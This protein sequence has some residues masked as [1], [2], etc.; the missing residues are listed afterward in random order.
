MIAEVTICVLAVGLVVC[1]V[2]ARRARRRADLIAFE[3]FINEGR[4]RILDHVQAV[5]SDDTEIG[6]GVDR[7]DE[8][9]R[10]EARR[11]VD[12]LSRRV[13]V[14]LDVDTARQLSLVIVSLG[15]IYRRAKPNS[16]LAELSG[17][18]LACLGID[19]VADSD[20]TPYDLAARFLALRH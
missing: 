4:C 11:I 20:A 7:G 14:P 9:E 5:V 8:V 10:A 2:V 12:E 17:G 19:R 1:A 13:P 18:A 16:Q 6:P 3:S 15:S